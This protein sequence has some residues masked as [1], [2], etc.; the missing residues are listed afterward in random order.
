MNA[1]LSGW[2]RDTRATAAIEFAILM[3]VF[4]LMLTGMMAYGIYF[5]A[6][7]SIQQLTAD[8]ARIAISGLD[9]TERN[10]LVGAFLTNNA[11]EYLLIDQ[12]KVSFTIGD[13]PGDPT[14]YRVTV[15]YDASDLPIWNLYLP[16]PLPSPLITYTSVIRRGGI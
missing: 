1:L 6:A 4:L 16:L 2:V 15:R 8:A 13:K 14:Q 11:G 12:A 9:Q 7:N 5:G 3:P 10:K